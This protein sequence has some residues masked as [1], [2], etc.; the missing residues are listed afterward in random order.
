MRCG[1]VR[2]GAVC[3]RLGIARLDVTGVGEVAIASIPCVRARDCA[4]DCARDRTT[5]AVVVVVV[6]AWVVT[7]WDEGSLDRARWI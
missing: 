1:A 2:C 3:G 4:H 6:S 5:D 7:R